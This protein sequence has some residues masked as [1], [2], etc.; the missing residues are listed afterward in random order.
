MRPDTTES[1]TVR[2]EPP[3]EPPTPTRVW[4]A[5]A[6][7]GAAMALAVVAQI[8]LSPNGRRYRQ[9]VANYL[10]GGGEANH[11]QRE[12]KSF[13]KGI[14]IPLRSTFC[15]HDGCSIVDHSV[16]E[17]ELAAAREPDDEEP[18]QEGV[19][20]VRWLANKLR[21]HP[22]ILVSGERRALG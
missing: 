15:S 21:G 8:A 3:G 2:D 16:E 1:D 18:D 10:E 5:F 6:V 22:S 13:A 19:G 17:H 20:L 7:V 9:S 4:P 14:E 11:P 12:W